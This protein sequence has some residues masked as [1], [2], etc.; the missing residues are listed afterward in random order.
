MGVVRG[1]LPP[2]IFIYDTDKVEGGLMVLFLGLVFSDVLPPGNF[3][4]DALEWS[5][6]KERSKWQHRLDLMM[7]K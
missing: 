2:W 1:G 3:S 6:S 5:G 7:L 4:A